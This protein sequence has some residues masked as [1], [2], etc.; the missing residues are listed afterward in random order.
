MNNCG[1]IF[2]RPRGMY[3]SLEHTGRVKEVLR[4]WPERDVRVICASSGA[5]AG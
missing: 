1:H 4:N 3:L 2:G 5:A